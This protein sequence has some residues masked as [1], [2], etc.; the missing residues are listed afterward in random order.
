MYELEKLDSNEAIFQGFRTCTKI[1]KQV[2][3]KVAA[4]SNNNQKWYAAI[5]HDRN[6]TNSFGV[7]V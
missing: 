7:Q 6:Q 2:V 4:L 5:W 1:F 3:K